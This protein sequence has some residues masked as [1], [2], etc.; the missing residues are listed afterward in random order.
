MSR[1]ALL[2]DLFITILVMALFLTL[3]FLSFYII[4]DCDWM[5][6]QGLKGFCLS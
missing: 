5:A 6:S 3:Y 4:P 1:K 2:R